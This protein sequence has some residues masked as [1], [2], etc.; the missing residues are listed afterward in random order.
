MANQRL[1]RVQSAMGDA[2]SA[3]VLRRVDAI[4]LR[5]RSELPVGSECLCEFQKQGAGSSSIGLSGRLRHSRLVLQPRLTFMSADSIP[6]DDHD[7][8]HYPRLMDYLGAV[9]NIIDDA[10]NRGM[11][12]NLVVVM[13][14]DFARTNKY[15]NDNGKDHWSHGSMMVWGAPGFFSGNRVVGLTD[16]NQVSQPIN[17]TTL[18]PDAGGVVLTNEYV[19]QALRDLAGVANNPMVTSQFPFGEQILPIFS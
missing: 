9:D 19:H 10:V 17:A 3:N 5:Q 16:D 2:E 12:D 15:N 7:V 4:G 14:S 1:D 11:G 13:T 6:M 18:Q 8:R